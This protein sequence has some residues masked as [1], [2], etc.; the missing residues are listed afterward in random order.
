MSLGLKHPEKEHATDHNLPNLSIASH[1]WIPCI[2]PYKGLIVTAPQPLDVELPF[3]P[4]VN[5]D[6][7]G[8]CGIRL[9]YLT[10]MVAHM[11]T[12]SYPII[13]LDFHYEHGY[14]DRFGCSGDSQISFFIDGPGGE[15]ISEVKVVVIDYVP[16]MSGLEVN[17]TTHFE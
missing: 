17:S 3:D 4:L 1:L 12:S 8:E 5:I 11:R 2:P 6:F 15:R 9:D 16:G 14:V 10:R 7:G 13:G